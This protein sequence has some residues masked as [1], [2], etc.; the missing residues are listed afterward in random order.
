MFLIASIMGEEL[1]KS[2]ESARSIP[3]EMKKPTTPESYRL[4]IPKA[5]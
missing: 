4:V 3:S 2:V 5:N 1:M